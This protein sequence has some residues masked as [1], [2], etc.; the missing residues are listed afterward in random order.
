MKKFKF[1]KGDWALVCDGG[2]AL[3]LK[4]IGDEAFF[5]LS[6]QASYADTPDRAESRRGAPGRVYESASPARSAIEQPH[7]RDEAE[8]RFLKEL[9]QVLHDRA[10]SGEIAHLIVAAPAKALGILRQA[11]TPAVRRLVGH[12]IAHD[13]TKLPIHDIE[14][15]IRLSLEKD[16]GRTAIEN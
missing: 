3:L 9:A 5:N 11:F 4:N 14:E 16:Q 1:A 13:L 6:L 12:E 7:W 2:K 8:R 10:V 15:H